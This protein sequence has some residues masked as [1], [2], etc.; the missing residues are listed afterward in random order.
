MVKT[1]TKIMNKRKY[2]KSLKGKGST[3]TT[4]TSYDPMLDPYVMQEETLLKKL[5]RIWKNLVS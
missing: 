3:T 4:T 1:T 2:V 5:E